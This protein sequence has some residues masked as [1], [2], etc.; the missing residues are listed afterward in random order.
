MYGGHRRNFAAEH[1]RRHSTRTRRRVPLTHGREY[2]ESEMWGN[3]EDWIRTITPMA[4]EEGIRLGI[5]LRPAGQA[6]RW[7]PQLLR[8]FEA[9]KRLIEITRAQR[10]ASNSA[11]ARFRRWRTTC[12]TY[13]LFR[14]PGKD[15]VRPF[16][17]CF[18]YGARLSGRIRELRFC[19]HVPAM[20]IYTRSA[21]TASSSTITCR[22][23]TAILNG[24]IG[25][26]FRKRL[27][28]GPHRSRDQTRTERGTSAGNAAGLDAPNSGRLQ[29]VAGESDAW[30]TPAVGAGPRPLRSR[31]TPN[32][33]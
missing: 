14:V 2:S 15:S 18:G 10:T 22:I 20:E 32:A 4:E 16:P 26:C 5:P 21:S 24:V 8:S 33:G 11:R 6:A 17:E 3:F 25:A 29:Q 31:S 7:Y 9:Y 27:H 1:A 13:S 23:R 28:S 12:T 30:V 19:R